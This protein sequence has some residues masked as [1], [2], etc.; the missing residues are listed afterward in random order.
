MRCDAIC[1]AHSF[2]INNLYESLKSSYAAQMYRDV[3]HIQHA[4]EADPTPCDLFFFSFGVVTC[5]GMDDK[6]CLRAIEQAAPYADH[7][8]EEIERDH[9][10]VK[11]G[12][13]ARIH[14]DTIW[15]Q[16]SDLFTRLGISY[17]IAQSVKLEAFE[18]AVNDT[19][20][21]TRTIPQELATN[22]RIPLSARAIRRMMGSLFLKRSSINLYFDVLDIPEIIWDYPTLEP[23]YRMT[24]QYLDVNARVEILNK[25][26]DIIHELFGMLSDELKHKHS[27]RLEW[28]II[29]L[30]VIEVIITFMKDVFEVL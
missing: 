15:I 9:F 20:N 16:D 25:R 5:W 3:L 23:L 8:L 28:T 14:N 19:I 24:S 7:L 17:G 4:S 10:E 27:S 2:N 21:E 1:S 22:G 18:T 13:M 12:E 26:L 29:W 11:F 6:H 30:I